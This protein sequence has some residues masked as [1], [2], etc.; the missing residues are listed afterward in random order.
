MVGVNPIYGVKR[1]I[2]RLQKGSILNLLVQLSSNLGLGFAAYYFKIHGVEL[3][4]II[5]IWAIT[6]LASLP[7]VFLSNNWNIKRYLTYGS[8]AYTGMALSLLFFNNYSFI[9]YGIF[10]GLC[11]G[12]FWVSLNYVFFLEST[13][14][15]H[16]K[17]SSIYFIL[18]PLVGIVLPPLG[19]L[20]IGGLG[21]RALFFISVIL[22]LL[23]LLYLRGKDLDITLQ[24]SFRSADKA[25]KGFRLITFFDGALHYF[26]GNFLAIYVLLFLRSQYQV[27]GLESYLALLS[28]VVSFFLS[29]VSDKSKKR[30]EIL[31]P[32][33]IV[34]S[35]LIMVMPSLK[36]LAAFIVIGGIYAV[37][38]NLSLPIRFAVPMDFVKLDIGFWRASEFYGNIGRTVVF[39]C[40]SLLLY[41]GSKWAAFG[42][43]AA[44]TL[45][46]PFII[47]RK[48]STLRKL[49]LS[50]EE[51]V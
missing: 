31:Y 47:S 51:V 29:H 16:A 37:L 4:K 12:F 6:P 34:M 9:L 14:D 50:T 23:P 5:L 22:T 30:V 26:Q 18:G 46:F 2:F 3:Y 25:F 17:D 24:K 13:H 19:S 28:L 35:V 48:I 21:Y 32:I 45:A 7:I 38:D 8:L 49:V 1:Y 43:F 39:G 10:N 44:M 40:A 42:I 33:L 36:D 15:N 20:I 11:L 41:L 27:G